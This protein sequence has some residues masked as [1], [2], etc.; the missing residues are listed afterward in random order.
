MAALIAWLLLAGPVWAAVGA[1]VVPGRYRHR[2]RDPRLAGLV[3]G[4]AGAALGP[5]ALA[6][7]VTRTPV[8]RR[9][10]H[11]VPA[12]VLLT[13][14]LGL[15]FRVLAP[16]D[17][18]VTSAGYVI[19]QVQNGLTVGAVYATMA[20]GLTLIFS[21]LGV[22]S[23]TH[24]QFVMLGGVMSYLLLTQVLPVNPLFVIPLAGAAGFLLGAVVEAGLLSPMHRGQV[25][26]KDEYAI[27]I[28]F[29]FGV[30]LQY[31]LLGVLGPTAGV[32]APRYTARP[33]FGLDT[34]LFTLGPLHLRTDFLIAGCAGALLVALLSWFLRRT[35]T[36]RSLRAVSMDNEAAAVAGID[37]AR[38]FT[39]AFGLGSA[40]AS[41]AGAALVP[42]L[43][44]SIPDI[45]S[46]AAVTSY[47]IIVL[48][49]LGSVPGAFLGG[50]SIGV[51]EAL[52]A[53]CYPD[54]SKG[55][56]YQTAFALVIFAI[57]LLVRPQGF[58]GRRQ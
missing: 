30:F 10:V 27:L 43:A 46:Q 40:L 21:V 7:L 29:G 16:A 14:E 32:M 39:F 36:G 55:A 23:F 34:A 25:E 37:S 35:W 24:G 8:V 18:C 28:T 47:V 22:V 52:G 50:L 58:L 48:G 41:M 56:V 44:F 1:W 9:G 20:V 17:P 54:P 31:T 12:G 2:G 53:G 26:R 33:L 3:G 45:A 38:T 19:D 11:V 5:L 15:L 57:A 4:L 13:L 6:Y 49:G 42:V 51:V